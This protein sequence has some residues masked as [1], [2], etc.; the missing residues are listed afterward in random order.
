VK[1]LLLS[2]VLTA[3]IATP[4]LAQS[5]NPEFGTG[6]VRGMSQTEQS[7]SDAN[8]AYA[9]EPAPARSSASPRHIQRPNVRH[10]S[11]TNQNKN[12]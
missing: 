5:Y 8:S 3:S 4:A 9:H 10:Q 12:D 11:A 7:G 6:N 2:A 1:K